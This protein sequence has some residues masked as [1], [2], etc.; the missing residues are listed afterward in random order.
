MTNK[1]NK[2]KT[3]GASL[4]PAETSATYRGKMAQ[5]VNLV[6]MFESHGLKLTEMET[7]AAA[8]RQGEK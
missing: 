3:G 7:F 5:A 4:N 2:F 6:E 1:V 8:A